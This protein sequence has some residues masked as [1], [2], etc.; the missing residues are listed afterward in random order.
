MIRLSNLTIEGYCSIGYFETCITN[1]RATIIRGRNGSGK[2]SFLSAIFW[3]L[4]GAHTKEGVKQV[5]T[6]KKFQGKDYKGTMVSQYFERD[7]HIHQVIR[8]S[9]YKGEVRGSKGNSRLIYVIDN[10]EIEE[11]RKGEIQSRI[12][13]DLGMS[14][15]LFLSSVMFG[16]GLKRLVQVPASDKKDIFEEIF[17]LGYLSEAQAIAKKEYQGL[18]ER[19]NKWISELNT[20]EKLLNEYKKLNLENKDALEVW[21]KSHERALGNLRATIKEVKHSLKQISSSQLEILLAKANVK[22]DQLMSKLD[23]SIA[24]YETKKEA[25]NITQPKALESFINQLILSIDRDP[26]KAKEQLLLMRD[27][28]NYVNNFHKASASAKERIFNLKEEISEIK[29]ELNKSSAL[30]KQLLSLKSE[31]LEVKSEPRPGKSTDYSAKVKAH[32]KEVELLNSRIAELRPQLDDYRWLIDGPLGNKGIKSYIFESSLGE[33]NEYMA[34][35]A[36]IMGFQVEF[37]IDL[38]SARKDFY[39]LIELEGNIVDYKEL[40]GGQ[41]Q[42]VHL[43]MAFATH[44]MSTKSLGINVLFLDEIFENLD[45]ENVDIVVSLIRKMAKD[46]SIYVISHKDSLPI[47]NANIIT[48]ERNGGLTS[49]S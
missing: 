32:T 9:N 14:S 49:F 33:L 4:Y 31:L 30:S 20:S 3:V 26:K 27:S 48:L 46:K 7:G 8:C 40:S 22:K 38:S 5:N 37:S 25:I 41:Q 18:I 39:T 23:L 24:E 45:A 15:Q 47:S 6:W 12:E 35:Y 36:N 13:A 2:S 17:N 44:T 10:E 28:I 16:Q 29:H 43:A 19:Y 42:L 11:K 1:N 21:S 34:S